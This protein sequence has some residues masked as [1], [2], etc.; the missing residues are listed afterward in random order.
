MLE[1][2][3]AVDPPD[4]AHIMNLDKSVRDFGVPALLD[5]HKSHSISPRFLVMQ[6]GLVAIS[7]ELGTSFH[8]SVRPEKEMLTIYIYNFIS[9]PPT[10]S[11]VFH[12]CYGFSGR[13]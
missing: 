8:L 9:S 12:R 4:Y 2:M 1:A 6:R 10:S 7:R 11:A 3:V 13:F 5:E